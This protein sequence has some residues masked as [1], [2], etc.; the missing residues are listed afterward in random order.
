M[1]VAK[2]GQRTVSSH[3]GSADVL[4]ALG[5]RLEIH[6]ASLERCIQEVGIGFLYGPL[7]YGG[8]NYPFTARREVGVRTLFRYHWHNALNRL[9]LD[10]NWHFD[11]IGTSAQTFGWDVVLDGQHAWLMDNGKHR[12][13]VKMIG[14]GVSQTPN[15]LVRVSM[16]DA[17][18]HQTIDVCGM[19]D[20]SITN[21]PL[22]DLQ[23]RIVL[24]YDSANRM[25]GAWRFDVDNKGLTLR[26][27]K[28]PFGCASHMVLYPDTGEVAVNDYRHHGEEVVVLDIASGTEKGRV[29]SGGLTQGVV[30][31]SVGWHRDFY[32]SSMG[33]LARIFVQ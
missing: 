3:C 25:L 24:A 30:F 27:K 5:I 1:K 4:D 20:G 31:P 10:S 9:V 8:I 6:L 29:R 18:D 13:T 33:R 22:Y 21:P 12:Y 2:H 17:S 11:Y 32:W 26:W 23:R 7:F 16:K 19:P 28:S 14:A 15:R